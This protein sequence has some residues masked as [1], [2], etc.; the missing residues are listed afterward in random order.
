M[1]LF[2]LGKELKNGSLKTPDGIENIAKLF[3]QLAH[4]PWVVNS[5]PPGKGKKK[6]VNIVRYLSRYVAKSAVSDKRIQKAENGNVYI[7]YY[8]RKRKQ[9]KIEVVT[10]IQFMKRLALHILPKGF[11]KVR[12]FGFMAN[13]NRANNLAL[14]RMFLG[15][16]LAEQYEQ[17][18]E[19]PDD[20][21]FLFW[22]YFRIDITLC[23]E[24][25]RGHIHYIHGLST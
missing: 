7:R 18:K 21:A 16:P 20:T 8:N 22:K 5:Q 15:Q 6:P 13:H 17:S 23:R 1:L 2:H 14:C 4:I 3:N 9:S 11:K 10:E 19:L 24:C 25:G 12:F